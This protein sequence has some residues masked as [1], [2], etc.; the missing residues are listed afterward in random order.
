MPEKQLQL[1][2]ELRSSVSVCIQDKNG[3][4][5]FQ[6]C[7]ELVDNRFLG[8]V[9]EEIQQSLGILVHHPYGCRVV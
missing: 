4:H 1:I 6:K 9:V 7:L 3:N 8:F 5:V 2:S